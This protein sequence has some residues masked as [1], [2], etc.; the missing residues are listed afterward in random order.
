MTLPTPQPAGAGAFWPR[1]PVRPVLYGRAAELTVI[2]RLVVAARAGPGR[3]P[4]HPGGTR[5]RQ[6]GP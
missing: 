3:G 1:P 6:V 2:D 5:D 4:G